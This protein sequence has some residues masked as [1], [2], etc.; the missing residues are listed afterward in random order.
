MEMLSQFHIFYCN[1]ILS[2]SQRDFLG[3]TKLVAWLSGK[4]ISI[5]R[6]SGCN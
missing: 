4:E 3:S 1:L 6:V 5:A 2:W